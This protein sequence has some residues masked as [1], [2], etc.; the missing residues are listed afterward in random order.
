MAMD[1][2]EP[3]CVV[4]GILTMGLNLLASRPKL[5]K[6]W[7]A[8]GVAIAVASGGQ[9]LGSIPV[10]AGDVLY[11]ALEDNRR[12]LK[13]R[14]AMLLGD[15]P[16]P[17]RLSIDTQWPRLDQGGLEQI[18]SWIKG[19]D[20]P[21]LIIIDTIA[22][23]RQL[24][25]V[26]ANAYSEDY[27]HLDTVKQLADAHDL[28]VLANHHTRKARAEDV[29]EEVSGTMGLTAAAD[30][31]MV[32]ARQRGQYDAVLHVTGRDVEEQNYA[33]AF[34]P[35]SGRWTKTGI[36]EPVSNS[37]ETDKLVEAM[38]EA[39]R[40]MSPTELAMILG[41]KPGTVTTLLWRAAD[42]GR[43]SC[44]GRGRYVAK[45]EPNGVAH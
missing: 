7:L 35:A 11:L 20:N 3:V 23:V 31:I 14:L 19:R 18:E 45:P 30:T 32:L 39:G 1:L 15:K 44:L 42:K 43:V 28:G 36:A 24:Q 34:D 16:A 10:E 8:L 13:K 4:D 38:V 5:G 33:L 26:R 2:P 9:A 12:R 37:D 25:S 6:S 29:L 40:E 17:P 41:K 22:K 21:R 27:Q